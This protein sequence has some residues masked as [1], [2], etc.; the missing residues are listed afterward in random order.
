MTT[1]LRAAGILIVAGA[2]TLWGTTTSA[3]TPTPAPA[4]SQTSATTASS[5]SSDEVRPAT[6][7][8]FGDTGI[9]FVP[10][11]EVLPAGKFSVSG[12]RRGT[13]YIQGYSNVADSGAT[14]A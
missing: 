10:T 12:Y 13:N 9:W 8:F 2:C 6:T 11:A 5:T 7:T 1:S 3:Q 14:R 4:A